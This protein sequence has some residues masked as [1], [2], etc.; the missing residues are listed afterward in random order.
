M[1]KLM[2]NGSILK[3]LLIKAT[4][5]CYFLL[6]VLLDVGFHYFTYELIHKTREFFSNPLPLENVLL[7]FRNHL[8]TLSVFSLILRYNCLSN[9]M[10]R[11]RNMNNKSKKVPNNFVSTGT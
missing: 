6:Y 8:S 2:K 7:L 11:I 5:M 1:K 3:I 9:Q 10:V 4:S